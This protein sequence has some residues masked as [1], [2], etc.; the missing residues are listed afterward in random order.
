MT[1]IKF[2]IEEWTELMLHLDFKNASE[3][4]EYIND[5][6]ENLY[7]YHCR[8]LICEALEKRIKNEGDENNG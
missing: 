4:S 3:L 1:T 5:C 2:P 6:V 8:R 7:N